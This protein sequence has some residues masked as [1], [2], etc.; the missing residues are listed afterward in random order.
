MKLWSA[1][2]LSKD[3]DYY[4]AAPKY[5]LTMLWASNVDQ[6]QYAY[7]YTLFR[8]IKLLLVTNEYSI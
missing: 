4:N 7:I 3:S 8:N 2:A 5:V 1:L 6:P